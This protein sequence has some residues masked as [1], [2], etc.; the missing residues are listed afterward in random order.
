LVLVYRFRGS[1]CYHQVGAWQ[2]PGRHSAGGVES[3]ISCSESKQEKTDFQAAKLRVLKPTPTVTNFLQQ[4]H[5]Y[6]NKATPPN[7]AT[8]WA[9][10]IQTT[11]PDD[12]N[13]IP[14]ILGGRKEMTIKSCSLRTCEMAQ[15][16]KALTTKPGDLNSFLG[17]HM[18]EE[19]NQL[20]QIVF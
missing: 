7:S 16:V 6:F 4:G 13:L 5:I 10:H 11:T 1:V 12:L 8:P 2:H 9:K 18:A 20:L 19:E 14:R 17:T 3:S 15:W